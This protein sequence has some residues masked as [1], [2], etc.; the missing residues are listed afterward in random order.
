MRQSEDPAFRQLL[1]RGREEKHT[2]D[3]IKQIQSLA[4]T[5]TS[6][7]LKDC[8]KLYLTNYLTNQESKGCI[9]HVD[10]EIFNIRA[11]DSQ[12]DSIIGTCS[13]LINETISLDN[14]PKLLT[15]LKIGV[16]ARV[17]L[18]NNLDVSD[19]LINGAM[20]KVLYM[21]FKRDIPLIGRIFVKF[22]DPKAGNSR[23]DLKL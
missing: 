14:T 10:S 21:D 16:G 13:V 23:K 1:N 2:L 22:D 18:T 7:S 20:D 19:R 17:M 6:V 12:T 3:D 15:V 9:I 11:V 4:N 5:G 8:L